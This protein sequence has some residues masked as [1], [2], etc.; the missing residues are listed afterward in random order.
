MCD[1]ELRMAETNASNNNLR[2]SM[3]CVFELAI[4]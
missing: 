1:V 4:G 2:P 3:A